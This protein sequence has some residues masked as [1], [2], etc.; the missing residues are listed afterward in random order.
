MTKTLQLEDGYSLVKDNNDLYLNYQ[1]PYKI[2]RAFKIKVESISFGNKVETFDGWG[3]YN[4]VDSYFYYEGKMSKKFDDARLC[5]ETK[6]YNEFEQSIN[7]RSCVRSIFD[8]QE[9][10]NF[11]NEE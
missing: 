8:G 9:I 4:Y 11:L 6:S 1:C 5:F 7:K 3:S 2:E 10:F